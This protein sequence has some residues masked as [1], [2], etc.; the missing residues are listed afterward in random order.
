MQARRQEFPER[1]SSTRN[2]SR[3]LRGRGSGGGSKPPEALGYL[4]QNPA[5]LQFSGI[6]F[7]LSKSPVFFKRFSSN[8]TPI[9]TFIVTVFKQN[10]DFNSAN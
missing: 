2:A 8:F 10:V 4:E 7:I 5:I 3:A 6:S 1:G 9:R